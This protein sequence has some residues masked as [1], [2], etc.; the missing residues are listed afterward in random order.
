[1]VRSA[2]RDENNNLLA[3]HRHTVVAM[4]ISE[5]L[6]PTSTYGMWSLLTGNTR[7]S[8]RY[9]PG[10]YSLIYDD[11]DAPECNNL[12]IKHSRALESLVTVQRCTQ[13]TAHASI[14]NYEME[15][16]R[17]SE[18]KREMKINSRCRLTSHL[19]ASAASSQLERTDR[20]III[21]MNEMHRAND[22]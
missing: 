20:K 12:T 7:W 1:M 22:T 8:T 16:E 17:A 19:I 9:G 14:R 4:R 6:T 13:H 5:S 10:S 3:S 18:S 15:K 2:K 11:D 21:K